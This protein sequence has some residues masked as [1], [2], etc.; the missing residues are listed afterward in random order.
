MTL[1]RALIYLSVLNIA[2]PIIYM[3]VAWKL[4]T[5]FVTKKDFERLEKQQE[6]HANAD[7]EQFAQLD[8]DIKELLQRTARLRENH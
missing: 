8:Q 1:E 5:L 7:T 3:A 6:H 2:V 4:S